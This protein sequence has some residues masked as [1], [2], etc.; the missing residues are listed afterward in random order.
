MS[1]APKILFYDIETAGVNALRS[2]LGFVIVFGYKWGHEKQAKTIC[3]DKNSLH[4][5]DDKRLLVKAS[6]LLDE[7]DLVVAHYGSVFD[8]R[9]IQGRL[10]INGL[11]P[12][13]NTK[14]RDTC[15]ITRSVANFSS[16]RLK[17]LAKILKLRNQKL[18]NNW[19]NAWFQVMQGNTK[20]LRD[21]AE[22]CKGDVLA[23]E[24]LYNTIRPFDN[25]HP[26]MFT[27][28]EKCG[29]CSSILHK[30]G[31]RF[32]GIYKYQRYRCSGCGRFDVG[33]QRITG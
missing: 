2:D 14:M 10:L 13:S 28:R 33:T 31:Y 17:H 20:T 22:Y 11:P 16:N 6:V 29:V 32:K 25:A 9:F 30:W 1:T 24:E 18:E 15:M 23:L 4:H 7:A 8:R 12:I 19:P 21:L 3:V 27:D 26:R 5:F